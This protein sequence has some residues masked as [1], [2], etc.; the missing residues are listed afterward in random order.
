[1][2]KISRYS[3]TQRTN[4]LRKD[5]YTVTEGRD[6]SRHEA[7]T[8]EDPTM[9]NSLLYTTGIMTLVGLSATGCVRHDRYDTA[10]T[11][12]HSLQEQLVNAQSERDTATN[13][14]S[15]RDRQ[16]AQAEA[17]IECTSRAI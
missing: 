7:P 9:R 17:N 1:M 14:L 12:T 4:P 5:W 6:G 16:L 13:A 3:V 15:V 10:R 2:Y 8:E 11:T